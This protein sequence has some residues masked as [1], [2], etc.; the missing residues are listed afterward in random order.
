MPGSGLAPA[1]KAVTDVGSLDRWLARGPMIGK[2]GVKKRG[3]GSL[4]PGG[5]AVAAGRGESSYSA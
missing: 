2:A 4:A 3:P 1:A 5:N